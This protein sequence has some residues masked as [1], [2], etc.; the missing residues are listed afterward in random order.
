[1]RAALAF[2]TALGRPAPPTAHALPWFPVVGAALG[3]VLGAGWWLA[4][5]V[6]PPLVAAALVVAADL[7]LTGLLHLDGLA[8]TADGLLAHALDRSRRLE[9]MAE[10]GVGAFGVGVTVV[11]LLL[12]TAAL[13]VMAPAPLLLAALW[14]LSRTVMAV[15]VCALPYA[16][17]RGLASSFLGASAAP[18]ALGGGVLAVALAASGGE[19]AAVAA[20][21]AAI[22]AAVAMFSLSLRR[23]GGFTG[24]VLGAAGVVAET[25][26]LLVAAGR[27]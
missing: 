13:A 1:M 3:L 9:I 22:G 5:Q 17:P 10:P 18:V 24:D 19:L 7:A 6:W 15:A 4:A 11:A 26:G 14:S 21:V 27:W 23:L 12:R 8:D 16:R 20:L 25:T 2:L